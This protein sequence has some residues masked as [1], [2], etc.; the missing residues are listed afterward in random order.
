MQI[1]ANVENCV[2]PRI[3]ARLPPVSRGVICYQLFISIVDHEQ[4]FCYL[5]RFNR[6]QQYY[7]LTA[8]LTLLL[9]DFVTFKN[10]KELNKYSRENII[11]WYPCRFDII[12]ETCK[13]DNEDI[14][15]VLTDNFYFCGFIVG[16]SSHDMLF[17]ISIYTS[18]KYFSVQRKQPIYYLES[19]R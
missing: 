16:E 9:S 7:A 4:R 5:S 14:F 2:C 8:I 6:I 19:L 13:N 11:A 12:E 17:N 1:D 3:F 10:W 15:N 18:L